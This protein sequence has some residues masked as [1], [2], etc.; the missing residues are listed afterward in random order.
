[1]TARTKARIA[2]ETA[3]LFALLVVLD[4]TLAGGQAFAAVQPN[5]LWLPV[6]ILATAYGTGAG[7][8][9]AAL[10]SA[11]WFLGARGSVHESD[12]LD[13]LLHLSLH[14]LMWFVA[15]GVLGETTLARARRTSWLRRRA[16]GAQRDVRRLGEVVG[17]LSATNRA[18][19]VRLATEQGDVGHIVALATGLAAVDPAQRREAICALVAQAAG[20]TDFTC[21]LTAADGRARAW[22]RGASAGARPE[23]LAE[24]LATLIRKRGRIMHV[25]RRADRV[26]LQ[27]VGVAALPL[28]RD[29]SDEAIGMLVFHDLPF[30]AL[31]TFG[32]A[33]LVQIGAW[34]S[35]LLADAPRVASRGG[36]VG[37]VA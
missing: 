36:G 4:R 30:R 15:A 3:A 29:G 23:A 16:D 14:P 28:R 12:Y 24:P 1:M 6:L 31:D 33:G 7:V 21:Y 37:L 26:P 18:L 35:P 13:R 34:L 8:V 2:L 11:Y 25:G 17:D 22:L 10:A 32:L 9:A 27:G 20:S 19:Q 5:P